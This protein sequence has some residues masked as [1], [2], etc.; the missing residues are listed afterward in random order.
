MFLSNLQQRVGDGFITTEPPLRY[1]YMWVPVNFL[2]RKKK[3]CLTVNSTPISNKNQNCTFT[4]NEAKQQI[5]N[6]Q[7]YYIISFHIRRKGYRFIS[8]SSSKFKWTI[9]WIWTETV[10]TRPS[11]GPLKSPKTNHDQTVKTV[12]L[13]VLLQWRK[14]LRPY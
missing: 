2:S 4:R 3:P 1:R 5:S 6:V 10:A 8:N 9:K 7:Q 13:Q 11:N 12:E 14:F